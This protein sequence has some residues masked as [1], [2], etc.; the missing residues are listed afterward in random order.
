MHF[1]SPATT[2][3]S[4]Y[5]SWKQLK[6]MIQ[7]LGTI[8]I[9]N[10]KDVILFKD[11]WLERPTVYQNVDFVVAEL[12]WIHGDIESGRIAT[13]QAHRWKQKFRNYG[14]HHAIF[15]ESSW[16]TL[17]FIVN[18]IMFVYPREQWT[19]L[20]ALFLFKAKW[21]KICYCTLKTDQKFQVLISTSTAC[22][23]LTCSSWLRD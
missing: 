22:L 7:N 19:M 13:L 23:V 12:I 5:H 17:M 3:S 20:Y 9:I 2:P 21:N 14:L 8:N 4:Q 1:Q 10:E 15:R 18:C 6:Q 11:A 16:G